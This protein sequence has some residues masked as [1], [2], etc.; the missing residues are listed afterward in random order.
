MSCLK[1]KIETLVY[2]MTLGGKNATALIGV[3]K[4]LIVSF[5]DL[6]KIWKSEFS[7]EVFI[8]S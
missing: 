2:L 1:V 8:L 5:S 4:P 6:I 3:E 7:R